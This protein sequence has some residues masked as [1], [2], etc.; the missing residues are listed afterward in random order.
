MVD[1]AVLLALIAI[2]VAAFTVLPVLVSAAQEEVE[3]RI[4]APEYVAGTFNATIDV[5][6][7]TD[8]NSGQFDHSFNSSV[9]N[10]T[11]MKEVEI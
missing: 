9:V 11:N 8:L 4:N 3:V 2:V 7:V 6:N 5:V 10:V 1:I